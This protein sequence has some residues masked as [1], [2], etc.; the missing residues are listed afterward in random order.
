MTAKQLLSHKWIIVAL[1]RR[2]RAN[3]PRA[4]GTPLDAHTPQSLNQHSYSDR[5]GGSSSAAGSAAGSSQR[6]RVVVEEDWSEVVQRTLQVLLASLVQEYTYC[7]TS[8][9]VRILVEE[10][11]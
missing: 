2:Q 7:F 1:A 9:K 11:D 8:T 6:S 3:T 10:V 4:A 5:R